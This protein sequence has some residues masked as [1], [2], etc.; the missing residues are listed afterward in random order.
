MHEVTHH[1]AFLQADE[2]DNQGKLFPFINSCH[3]YETSLSFV[4]MKRFL[5]QMLCMFKIRLGEYFLEHDMNTAGKV[6]YFNSRPRLFQYSSL[7]P[8]V[9]L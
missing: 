9:F 4:L 2:A 3:E 5:L 8:C 1:L 7:K 6:N